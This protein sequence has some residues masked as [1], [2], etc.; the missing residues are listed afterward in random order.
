[1][2]RKTKVQCIYHNRKLLKLKYKLKAI[3]FDISTVKEFSAS[4]K[5][6]ESKL[7]SSPEAFKNLKTHVLVASQKS[8]VSLDATVSS[9]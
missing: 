6:L 4:T 9:E 7:T 8:K 1:M 2:L 3:Y 5:K